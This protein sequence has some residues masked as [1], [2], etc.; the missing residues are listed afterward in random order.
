MI[1]KRK[2]ASATINLPTALLGKRLLTIAGVATPMS[3]DALDENLLNAD[4]DD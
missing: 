2:T 4:N 1:E 3:A